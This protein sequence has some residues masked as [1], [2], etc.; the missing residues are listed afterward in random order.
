M[1]VDTKLNY[2]ALFKTAFWS[3]V[4]KEVGFNDISH[5]GDFMLKKGPGLQKEVADP[6]PKC[7]HEEIEARLSSFYGR[8][9][10]LPQMTEAGI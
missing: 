2:V 4:W 1:L 8:E 3:P 7:T 6:K 10:R 9:I 5:M